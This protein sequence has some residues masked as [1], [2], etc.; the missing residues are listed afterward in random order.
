MPF[1]KSPEGWVIEV[2]DEEHMGPAMKRLN[3]R[4]RRYVAALA[5]YGGNQTLAYQFAGY[6]VTNNNSAR[7]ASSRLSNSADIKEAIREE[8]W[9][10][11]D[12]SSL[13]AIS[14]L[15]E[16]AMPDNTD[17]TSRLKAIDMLTKRNGFHEKTEH[18]VTH[19]DN[20]TTKELVD[21]I[22]S[23]TARLGLGAPKQLTVID[24]T[25]EEV[26]APSTDGIEDLF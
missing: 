10:R 19:Q 13:L 11:L 2:P 14:G 21:F 9:R 6:D 24:T 16:L 5:V 20:R 18:L 12:S 4:Q 8:A 26:I 25:A 7:A 17:K 1:E 3:E 23:M 15:I 22:Q